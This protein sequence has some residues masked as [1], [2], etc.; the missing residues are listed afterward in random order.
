MITE[1]YDSEGSSTS[2]LLALRLVTGR[3]EAEAVID[4]YADAARL[5]GVCPSDCEVTI[6]EGRRD[7][8]DAEKAARETLLAV[9]EI[10][11]DLHAALVA[12]AALRSVTGIERGTRY[13]VCDET[14]LCYQLKGQSES[15]G[16]MAGIGRSGRNWR[17][18]TTHIGTFRST[19][20]ATLEDFKTFRVS[21]KG[22]IVH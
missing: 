10:I 3:G 1:A 20:E 22:H 6:A 4:M 14:T 9:D 2:A 21:P 19:R 18:G 5:H 15:L 17:D 12:E 7:R 13:L 11:A 8:R 16:I